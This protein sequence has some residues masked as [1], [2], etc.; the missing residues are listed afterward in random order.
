M[1]KLIYYTLSHNLKYLDL[2]KL[3]IESLIK[4]NY[5]GSFLFITNFKKQILENINV[6]NKL[7][8]IEAFD[9]G[10]LNSSANKFKIYK[11]DKIDEFDKILYVDVDVLFV[12]NV[13]VIFNEIN[14]D[15]IY[16]SF[17]NPTVFGNAKESGFNTLMTTKCGAQISWWGADI[18]LQ[19]EKNYIKRKKIQAINAGIFAFKP[20]MASHFENIE[21]FMIENNHFLNQA[22]EQP[23]FNVYLFRKNLFDST[24]TKYV[25]HNT[26]D[27]DGKIIIHFAGNTGNFEQKINNFKSFLNYS[28]SH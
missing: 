24:L 7:Y 4:N 11:F 6:T 21:K 14:D 22:L 28:N 10:L 19:E 15:K 18:F 12:K 17:D 2:L 20:N 23:F 9:D 3:N 27:V 1:K 16:V 8:F 26:N 25:T 13:D 5:D